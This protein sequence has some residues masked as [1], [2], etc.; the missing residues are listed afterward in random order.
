MKAEALISSARRARLAAAGVTVA[1]VVAVVAGVMVTNAY[2]R[3]Q[4]SNAAA[5][6]AVLRVA[7]LAGY[8]VA[9]VGAN[10]YEATVRLTFPSAVISAADVE[11]AWET[12]MAMLSVAYPTSRDYR[13]DIAIPDGVFASISGRGSTIRREV[14]ADD[15]DALRRALGFATLIG[16]EG[17]GMPSDSNSTA[18]REA[19]LDAANLSVGYLSVSGPTIAGADAL[20]R[21]WREAYRRTPGIPAPAG[22]AQAVA[23]FWVERV[24]AALARIEIKGVEQLRSLLPAWVSSGDV[25]NA[26]AWSA[27]CDAAAATRAVGGDVLGLTASATRTVLDAPRGTGGPSKYSQREWPIRSL[28]RAPSL[29]ASASIDGTGFP[30]EALARYGTR[31][32]GIMGFAW[33]NGEASTGASMR[34]AGPQRWVAYRGAWRRIYW[35]AGED[36]EVALTDSALRGWGYRVPSASLVDAANTDRVVASFPRMTVQ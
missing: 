25:A 12:G 3:H 29:D 34:F 33:S 31:Q 28:E 36:G 20:A 8:P 4:R 19:D 1:L 32:S 7:R 10:S 17:P 23:K 15:P 5:N 6:D 13:V 16:D 14:E 24:S 21:V 9:E 11:L 27:L 26:R 30:A 18:G 22:G 2:E 35:L